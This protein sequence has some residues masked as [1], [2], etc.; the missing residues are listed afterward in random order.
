MNRIAGIVVAAIGF[1]IAVMSV[2]KVVP[3][4]TSTGV[5]LIIL[6]GL[7]IG[8]SFVSAPDPGDTER[9]S[10]P[11]SLINIFLSPGEVFQNLRRHPRWLVAALIMTLMSATFSNLFLYR[12][13]PERVTNFAIDKTLEMPMMNDDAR[14]QVEAGR[15]AAL[16][17]ARNPVTRAGQAVG[18]FA[19]AIIGYS[20]LA[21][22]FLLFAL[23]MGGKINFF[24]AFSIAVY[25]NF[26]LAVI[27]FIL[28]TVLLFIKDPTDIHPITGQSS[29]IQDNFSFLV[30]PAEH[31][32]IYT[33]L[34]TISILG[35]YWIWMNATGLKNGGE[36]VT[37]TTGWAASLSVYGLLM[38]LAVSMAALF[39]GFIG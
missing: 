10:T 32:V 7:V 37:G 34:A 1:V 21:G 29:L 31:P 36:R 26:P 16:A 6:G 19:W 13:T 35:I 33:F 5:M 27:R 23:A 22:I 2:L 38:M 3:G 4:I 18:G 14:K 11:S 28:N 25:A 12:L 15:P 39:P 8:L 20:L 30:V 17:D 9:M 24:Q